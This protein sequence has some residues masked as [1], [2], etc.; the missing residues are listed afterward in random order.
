LYPVFFKRRLP[1]HLALASLLV[2]TPIFLPQ[3]GLLENWAGYILGPLFF[4]GFLYLIWQGEL[5]R[6]WNRDQRAQRPART[7]ELRGLWL[8]WAG[9]FPIGFDFV[10]SAILRSYYPYRYFGQTIGGSLLL[11]G[12]VLLGIGLLLDWRSFPVEVDRLA[13]RSLLLMKDAGFELDDSRL[14]VGIDSTI[15]PLGYGYSHPAG[16]DYVILVSPG[17]IYG[18]EA[19]GLGQTLV[20]EMSHAYL[21]QKKHPSHLREA[22]K[23]AYSRTREVCRKKWQLSIVQSAMRYP[24]EAFAEDLTFKTLKEAKNDWA[25][26][27]LQY[28]QRLSRRRRIVSTHRKQGSWRNA[29]LILRNCYYLAEMERYLMPDPEG[30]TKRTNERLLSSLPPFA[31]TA[32][33]YY[34]KVFLG[35]RENITTEDYKKTSEEYLSKFI[36]LAEGRSD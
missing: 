22:F 35:L 8:M 1:L 11:G 5:F 18:M 28:F 17:S 12:T 14:W 3:L 29:S 32:F 26:A 2:G 4:G 21:T 15:G 31:S 13:R 34:R 23:E 36:A 27:A 24:V 9:Y 16:D 30:I 6:A 7:F 19:G 10:Y 33:D 20:H 25:I